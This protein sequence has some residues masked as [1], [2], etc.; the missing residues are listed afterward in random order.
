MILTA[1]CGGDQYE[2]APVPGPGTV[3]YDGEPLAGAE[4]VFA[5]ME[6]DDEMRVGPVSIGVTDSDETYTLK[7]L[8]GVEGAVVTNHRVSVGFSRFWRV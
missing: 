1:G 3:T 6:S 7:T 5:P 8:K 2:M 4:V